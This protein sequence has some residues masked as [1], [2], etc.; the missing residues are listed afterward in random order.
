M[1]QA[2]KRNWNAIVKSPGNNAQLRRD[3]CGAI[4]RADASERQAD[5][6]TRTAEADLRSTV[7]RVRQKTESHENALRAWIQP[8]RDLAPLIRI[9]TR[10]GAP[11]ADLRAFDT[12]DRTRRPQIQIN[13]ASKLVAARRAEEVAHL[14]GKSRR[15]A[16]DARRDEFARASFGQGQGNTYVP[17]GDGNDD[18]KLGLWIRSDANHNIV[19]RTAIK[20]VCFDRYPDGWD[21]AITWQNADDPLNKVL[22]EAHVME[23]LGALDSPNVVRLRTWELHHAELVFRVS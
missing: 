5:A 15:Q 2:I 13:E 17:L 3:L 11:A 9:E 4:A 12:G 8:L 19:E 18:S 10:I 23:R 16:I 21:D 7:S 6:A 1:R 22:T 14:G 20:D